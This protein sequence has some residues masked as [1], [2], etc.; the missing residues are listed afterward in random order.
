MPG[1]YGTPS[2]L[3]LSLTSERVEQLLIAKAKAKIISNFFIIS[4]YT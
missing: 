1:I 3:T 2:P 4:I